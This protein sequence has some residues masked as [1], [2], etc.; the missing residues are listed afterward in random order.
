MHARMHAQ[1]HARARAHTHTRTH[2]RTHKMRTC[3][4]AHIHTHTSIHKRNGQPNL[5]RLK[6]AAAWQPSSSTSHHDAWYSY[7]SDTLF[8]EVHLPAVVAIEDTSWC[9]PSKPNVAAVAAQ[10]WVV[11]RIFA[12]IVLE[13]AIITVK[14]PTLHSQPL[15]DCVA[16]STLKLAV[17]G[18][19]PDNVRS[20]VVR[21]QVRLP[22]V[23]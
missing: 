3:T 19:D 2:A 14:R 9:L 20:F 8:L 10:S 1:K 15:C 16:L 23:L 21:G 12:A 7:I 13:P 17:Q 22:C 5:P 6:S 4:H 18:C 11:T